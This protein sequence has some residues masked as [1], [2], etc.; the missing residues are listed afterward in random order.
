MPMR[1]QD[2]FNRRTMKIIVMAVACSL[3]LTTFAA[4]QEKPAA[5]STALAPALEAK[6]R[7]V[8]EDFKNKNKESLAAALADGFRMVE[9]GT[10]GFGDKKADLATVDELELISYTLKDFT[11]K[12]LGPRAALVTYVAHYESKSGGL[13]A[14]ADSIFG[15]VWT[16][17]G[18]D[19][20][21]LYL[22]ETYIQETTAK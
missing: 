1:A 21:A 19:W 13:V 9:E 6:V 17:E 20:K 18:N 15:E 11:V 4:A 2:K 3:L 7:K 5:K 22:Q 16:R 12:S 14:K 8:W 10:S